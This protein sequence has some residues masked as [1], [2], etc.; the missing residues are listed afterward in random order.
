MRRGGHRVVFL[1]ATTKTKH[2]STAPSLFTLL[3]GR[4]FSGAVSL[5]VFVRRPVD[6]VLSDTVRPEGAVRGGY[7]KR[8][9]GAGAGTT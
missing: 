1:I 6:N 4:D 2:E 9:R 7:G 8:E 3:V 5:P